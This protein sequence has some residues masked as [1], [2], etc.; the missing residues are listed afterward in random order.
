MIP[1]AISLGTKE[2]I[3]AALLMVALNLYNDHTETKPALLYNTAGS[4]TIYS[5]GSY[6]CPYYCG[7]R[8]VHQAHLTSYDCGLDGCTHFEVNVDSLDRIFK[9]KKSCKSIKK[10]I[11]LTTDTLHV[12]SLLYK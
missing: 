7:A 2:G 5:K 12:S 8:H 1:V 11:K 4:V 3:I 10:S 6:F 9:V